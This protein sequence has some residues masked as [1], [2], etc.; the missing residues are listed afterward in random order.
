MP[1]SGS[2]DNIYRLREGIERFLIADI[3]NPAA[4][5]QAQSELY[6]MLDSV[7]TVVADYNHLPGGSN[8]LYM[9]GHVEYERYQQFGKDPVN[10]PL[11]LI[12]GA[13]VG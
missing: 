3:N 9:D 11:A 5:A 2:S 6:I 13:I 7:S 12:I 8:V 1:D 4:S 10:G